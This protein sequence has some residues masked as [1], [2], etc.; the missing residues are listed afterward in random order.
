VV[1]T[2]TPSANSLDGH[3]I[4][5]SC[6]FFFDFLSTDIGNELVFVGFEDRTER[7]KYQNANHDDSMKLFVA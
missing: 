2:S 1:S 7:E 4:L 5:A 3:A 6:T